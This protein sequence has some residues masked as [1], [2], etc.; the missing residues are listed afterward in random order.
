MT[1][2][3][4]LLP[5]E[6]RI[7]STDV[8]TGGGEDKEYIGITGVLPGQSD[9]AAKRV[10]RQFHLKFQKA[11]IS[12]MEPSSVH[13]RTALTDLNLQDAL[14]EEARLAAERY[15]ETQ[16]NRKIRGGPW[17]RTRL[18][19]TDKAEIQLTVS[20]SSRVAVKALALT[21]PHGPLA[22]HLSNESYTEEAV[23]APFVG[24]GIACVPKEVAPANF[25]GYFAK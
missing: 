19:P 15:L 25:F 18:P 2:V 24:Q 8:N 12:G 9:E 1:D 22:K 17:C 11:W 10:R 5:R 23:L 3:V 13:L 4:R 7:C 14:I 20:C 6:L 21:K 16:G